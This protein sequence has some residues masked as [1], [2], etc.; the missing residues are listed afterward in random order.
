MQG[1]DW[2]KRQRIPMGGIFKLNRFP[3]GDSAEFRLNPSAII[4]QVRFMGKLIFLGNFGEQSGKSEISGKAPGGW[5]PDFL[6]L[7]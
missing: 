4:H 7:G 5:W 6:L 2:Q 3:S 1:R